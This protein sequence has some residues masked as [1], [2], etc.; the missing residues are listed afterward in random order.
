M[1]TGEWST[2]GELNFSF[3]AADAGSNGFLSRSDFERVLRSLDLGLTKGELVRLLDTFDRSRDGRVDYPSFV[4]WAAAESATRFAPDLDRLR[5]KISAVMRGFAN[6]VDVR[7]AFEAL[8]T[9]RTG[10]L[11]VA[12]VR[13]V[14]AQ[15]QWPLSNNDFYALCTR[16]AA[17]GS[18]DVAG[19]R[20]GQLCAFLQLD[21]AGVHA[22]ETRLAGFI[23]AQRK[24]AVVAAMEAFDPTGADVIAEADARRAFAAMGFT[25]SE[26]ELRV[27]LSRLGPAVAVS[28]GG[29]GG[30]GG[31]VRYRQLLAALAGVAKRT[32]TETALTVPASAA[33][34]P[35]Q[36]AGA[37][38]ALLETG[39]WTT[40]AALDWTGGLA[41]LQGP[42]LPVG[43][44]GSVGEWLENTA[45]PIERRNF[46]ELLQLLSAFERKMGLQQARALARPH[47]EG[48]TLQLGSQLMVRLQFALHSLP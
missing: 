3:R 24:D 36:S 9:E 27:L 10:T 41:G 13:R 6:A 15:L 23:A 7:A 45:S 25:V 31:G 28:G 30:G 22:L 39:Q 40:G 16:F 46:F 44:R 5:D 43:A 18:V 1:H 17:G 20:Y 48:I 42:S 2:P 4:R 29:G 32:A 11:P 33:A 37:T 34:Y 21:T 38:G 26:D 47:E 12:A 14:A 35:F 8:D 19:V